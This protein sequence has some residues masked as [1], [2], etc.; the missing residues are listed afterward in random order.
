MPSTLKRT[1]TT[2][3]VEELLDFMDKMAIYIT[4]DYQV[5]MAEYNQAQCAS[6]DRLVKDLR[7]EGLDII[8]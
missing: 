5:E 1:P 7:G 3:E 8:V 6:V 2:S 4:D